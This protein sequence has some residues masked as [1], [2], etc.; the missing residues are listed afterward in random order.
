M[1]NDLPQHARERLADMRARKL[2]TSD[3]SVSEFLLVKEAGFDPLG[4]VMGSSIYQITPT[5]P[6]LSHNEPGCELVDM[7]RAL[8]HARELAMNRMEEEADALGADG[9]VGVRLTVRLGTNPI[10]WE[11][12][13]YREWQDWARGVGFPRS[14]TL[15]GVQWQYWRRAADP[16]WSHYCRQLGWMP[17]PPSPWNRPRAQT[18]YSFGQNAA[19]FMAIGCAVRHRGGESYKNVHGKPFQSDLS[20]QDFWTLIRTGF[21]PVGFVMGNCVYYVPPHLLQA[22]AGNSQELAAYTHAL[23]DAREL[24]TE[25]LQDEAEALQATGIVG[26]TFAEREHS[27]R[28]TPWMAGNAAL[29]SGEVIELFVVGTAVIPSG[30]PSD[31]AKPFLVLNASDPA[32][33]APKG[34]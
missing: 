12:D 8:Y 18:A 14:A 34:E 26:V 22:P 11:W 10:K 27:G 2:F 23:Y 24:A 33:S 21:R 25:R 1:S 4:L 32:S 31:L 17:E 19:E 6:Q 13:M 9:I 30:G 16:M 7:T 29:Q 15:L 20:G 3:L 28:V 5:L